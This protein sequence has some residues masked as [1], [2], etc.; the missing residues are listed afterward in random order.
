MGIVTKRSA[1]ARLTMNQLVT[2]CKD[3]S[4]Y[5]LDAKKKW[6]STLDTC[7]IMFSHTHTLIICYLNMTR[8]FPNNAKM[9][10]MINAKPQ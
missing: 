5:T 1:N 8:M 10:R 2:V 9:G 6:R 4:R 3:R 7:D